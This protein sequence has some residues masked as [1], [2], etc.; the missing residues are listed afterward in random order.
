MNKTELKLKLNFSVLKHFLNLSPYR[1]LSQSDKQ[2]KE[3]IILLKLQWKHIYIQT[4]LEF[5]FKQSYNNDMFKQ[6]SKEK[7]LLIEIVLS[8]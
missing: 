1:S 2:L 5:T 7:R 6:N 4:R 3:K 8:M